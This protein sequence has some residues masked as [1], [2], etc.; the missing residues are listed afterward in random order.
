MTNIAMENASATA[1]D[2]DDYN[3]GTHLLVYR[4]HLWWL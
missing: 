4:T 1:M 2:H 3:N